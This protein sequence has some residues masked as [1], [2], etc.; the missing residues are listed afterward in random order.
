M[1][2]TIRLFRI[3]LFVTAVAGVGLVLRWATAGTLENLSTDDFGS[4]ATLVAGGI[5]WAAHAWLCLAI[6]VTVLERVPGTLGRA[7]STVAGGITSDAS[8]T[9]LRSALG[10][11][12]VSPLVAGTAHAAPAG[13]GAS[14]S[15]HA[16]W[17]PVEQ[18]SSLPWTSASPSSWD[19]RVGVEPGSSVPW[20]GTAPSNW[21]PRAGVESGS[22][23]PTADRS[24]T[25]WSPRGGTEPA[26]TVRFEPAGGVDRSQPRLAIPDRP[27]TGAETRYTPIQPTK[28]PAHKPTHHKPVEHRPVEDRPVEDR[29]VEGKPDRPG[30]Q[31]GRTVVVREGDSLWAI[32]AAEL[33]PGADGAAIAARWPQWYA[34][35]AALIGSDPDLIQPGQVLHAPG[36]PPAS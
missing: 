28:P 24:A 20:T 12:V 25:S 30:E 21:D 18:A 16:Q 22:T 29:P 4:L 11:A 36:E 6:V 10:V 31:S 27:T 15:V 8:R 5:A 32:A 34:A 2:A 7:A 14:H 35:N 3:L 23:M 13:G 17:A 1:N 19:P 26:S 33:G 9:L